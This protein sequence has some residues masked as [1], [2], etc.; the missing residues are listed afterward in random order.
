VDLTNATGDQNREAPPGGTVTAPLSVRNSGGTVVKGPVLSV[1][2]DYAF[3]F[4]NRY[5]N[6][7]YG[8][9]NAGAV[10]RFD[11]T[12]EPG[13]EY[14][15]SDPLTFTMRPDTEAPSVQAAE[16]LWDTPADADEWL[17]SWRSRQPVPG[18]GGVLRLRPGVPV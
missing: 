4:A 6:C 2:N 15:L 10:C 1:F 3:T 17:G 8:P 18:N 16:Y 14:R 5:S 12:V 9:G 7:E 13:A 11:A